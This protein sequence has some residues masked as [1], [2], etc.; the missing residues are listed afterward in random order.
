MKYGVKKEGLLLIAGIVWLTAGV[1]I[2]RIGILTWISS[3]QYPL[4]KLCEATLVFL[5]FFIFIFKRLYD[6]HTKRI[7]EKEEGNHCPFAF[8]DLKSWLVMG[9]MI[10]LGIS[11]R[12]FHLLPDTIISFFYT[13]L[14][15]A[16]ML[17]GLLFIRYWWL[18]NK[19][20]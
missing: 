15:M 11:V 6:K 14:S 8:F 4:F 20:K 10:S 18:K 19:N 13:G 3:A 12:T 5:F 2:L 7:D 1:N 9:F 17:T 16:L